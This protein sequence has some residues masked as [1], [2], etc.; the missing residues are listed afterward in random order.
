MTTV[1]VSGGFDYFADYVKNKLGID[2]RGCNY[3]ILCGDDEVSK[4]S[5]AIKN[6]EIG[7]QM[8]DSLKDRND[9]KDS[10]GSQKTVTLDKLLDEII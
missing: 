7:K 8:S 10:S 9:W 4:N 1:L 5:V 3:V 6:L 2:K